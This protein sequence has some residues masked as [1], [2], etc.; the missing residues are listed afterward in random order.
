MNLGGSND[1]TI[2][3]PKYMKGLVTHWDVG[4]AVDM[5]ALID[6][7]DRKRVYIYKYLWTGS[8]SQ[9]QKVQASWS[10][11]EFA[12]EVQW[13]RF[14]D[15]VLNMVVTTSE[16]TFYCHV[17]PEEAQGVE[18]GATPIV[19]LDRRLDRPYHQ[20]APTTGKGR[21]LPMTAPQIR[22]P[23]RCPTHQPMR[24]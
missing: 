15:N 23:S 19:H 2:N 10:T 5:A 12:Y 6:P 21:S 3:L 11:W 7:Q 4:E 22:P 24:S 13:V 8:A 16:G 20:F 9:V 18:D 1:I 17:K 14:M